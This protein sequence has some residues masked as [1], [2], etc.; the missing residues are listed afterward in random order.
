MSTLLFPGRHLVNTRFQAE[1]LQGILGREPGKIPALQAGVTVPKDRLDRV[2]FA[3]TSS[4]QDNSRYNPIPFH[5]RAIGVDRFAR[6]LQRTVAFTYRIVGI[7]HYGHTANFAAFTLKEIVAQTE[8]DETLRPDNTVVLCSTPEVASLYV[9]LGFA[10]AP[11]EHVAL[12]PK[13]AVPIEIIRAIGAGS[14]RWEDLAVVQSDLSPATRSLFADSPEIPRRITRIYRDPLT[15][16]EGSLTEKRNY[17]TYA[18][19]MNGTIR[20]K[21]QDIREAIRPGRIVDEGCADGALLVEIARDFPDSD[22][23]GIDLSAEFAAR[24]HER[25][26]SGEFGN[27]YTCFYLRNLLDPIFEPESVDTTICNSTL[28]ELWSYAE[29]EKTV[30]G[31]LAQKYAQLQPGGRLIVRDVVGPE[32]GDTMVVLRCRADDGEERAPA[33]V[34][35]SRP[36]EL[37]KTLSTRSRF[38][39]F[40]E[41][42]L[43]DLRT[44]GRRTMETCVACRETPEGF[45]LPLRSA[46]EFLS[47]KDYTDNWCSEMNEEFC[48]WSYSRWKEGLRE[49]GFNILEEGAQ[50]KSASRVYAN[51]WIVDNRYRN[52]ARLFAAGTGQQIEYPPTN[53]VLVAEKPLRGNA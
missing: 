52:Q 17:N 24:F 5:V 34:P 50:G 35:P 23:F 41:D 6:E 37:L 25:K 19:G 2:I 29:Q 38:R 12:A 48:F 33:D 15:N 44:S 28:H 18:R 51:P 32:N 7:P 46:A 27:V 3:I 22:L 31:Y 4:N 10:V 20:N 14:G 26:R 36:A 42:F 1:Y 49:V 53:M 30:R 45:E 40:L 39:L 21:Y 13:P 43:R 8:H 16:H 9:Q 47:K 11:A